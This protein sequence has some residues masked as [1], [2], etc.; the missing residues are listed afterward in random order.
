M[1][2]LGY[3]ASFTDIYTAPDP[4]GYLREL[5]QY[6][7]QV[8]Q[9]ALPWILPQ[10]PAG[11]PES[12]Q[13]LD[14]CCSYGF[15]AMLLN[16][17]ASLWQ[18]R[19]RYQDPS[20]DDVAPADLIAQDRDFYASMRSKRAQIRGLDISQPAIDYATGA[21]L[22]EAGWAENLEEHAPSASLADG[23]CGTQ[24]I[25][26]TG[27]ISYITDATITR[28]LEC[29]ERPGEV[30]AALFA[31]RQFD[32]GPIQEAFARFGVTLTRQPGAHLRQRQFVSEDE[33][34]Q[35][36]KETEKRGLDPTG[37][38]ADGWYYADVFLTQP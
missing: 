35:A 7:Y 5:S 17:T 1:S 16:H 18:L 34:T 19:A 30:R 9:N 14:L 8:P 26:C 6:D 24:L 15:N 21:G 12:T 29:L 37:L 13:V 38:E 11:Q 2:T 31:L 36:V 33:H 20:L 3:K 32:M 23:I 22:L 25:T 10:L 4:R 28:V 27:G